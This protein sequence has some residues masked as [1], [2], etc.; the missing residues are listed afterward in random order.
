MILR[1]KLERN[2]LNSIMQIGLMHL[3]FSH[4]IFLVQYDLSID[5]TCNKIMKNIIARAIYVQNTI[6]NF[7]SHFKYVT[8]S[9]KTL[10]VCVQILTYF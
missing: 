4:L 6:L 1:N 10:Y 9:S 8:S 5:L 3:L 2:N 7:N